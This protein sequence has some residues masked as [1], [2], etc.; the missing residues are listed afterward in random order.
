MIRLPRQLTDG[1]TNDGPCC[2]KTPD[3][4]S[5][6]GDTDPPIDSWAS[7]RNTDSKICS[8]GSGSGGFSYGSKVPRKRD[9]SK[10]RDRLT[11]ATLEETVAEVADTHRSGTSVSPDRVTVI[12][13]F[14]LL[15]PT[16]LRCIYKILFS[17]SA[18]DVANSVYTNLIHHPEGT[19]EH[20]ACEGVTTADRSQWSRCGCLYAA[21]RELD[22]DLT[23][24]EAADVTD[25]SP[26]IL[27]SAYQGHQE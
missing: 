21:V 3:R 19:C 17:V 8:P 14:H 5:G 4:E 15:A 25:V 9:Y 16:F 7:Y 24:A 26:V 22:A 13:I 12:H 2:S 23:Q 20:R 6:L 1:S 18:Y 10:R 11:T 27:R